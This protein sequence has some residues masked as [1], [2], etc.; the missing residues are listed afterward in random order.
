M[1]LLVVELGNM[2]PF[3]RLTRYWRATLMSNAAYDGLRHQVP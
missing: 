3:L 1:Q 2:E